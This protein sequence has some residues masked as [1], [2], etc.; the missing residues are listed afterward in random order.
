MFQPLIVTIRER[1]FLYTIA[2]VLIVIICNTVLNVIM[3]GIVD[4]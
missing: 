3:A 1:K 4:K 2:N